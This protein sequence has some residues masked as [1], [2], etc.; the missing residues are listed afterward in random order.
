M[1]SFKL[2]F[3]GV[4]ILQ[5]VEFFIFLLI[6]ACALQQCSAM[7]LPVIVWCE[8]RCLKCANVQ[9][10]RQPTLSSK[11]TSLYMLYGLTCLEAQLM[12]QHC[13]I[14]QGFRQ[15]YE[16][17][18]RISQTHC[19]NWCYWHQRVIFVIFGHVIFSERELMFTFAICHRPSVCRLS[20]CL[21]SVTFVHPTQAIEIFGSVSTP[22]GTFA[23]HDRCIKIL[24]RSSQGNPFVGG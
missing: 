8:V 1:Q 13:Y 24:R 14:V 18:L 11:R 22:C 5:G 12:K 20:F 10:Q 16:S 9:H 7:A 23:I 3:L 21:S 19:I 2:R 15:A 17:N 6:F 4:T